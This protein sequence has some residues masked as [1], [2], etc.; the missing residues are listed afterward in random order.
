MKIV[1]RIEFETHE[2]EKQAEMLNKIIEI[3]A[4]TAYTEVEKETALNSIREQISLMNSS[5]A[6]MAFTLGYNAGRGNA[7]EKDLEMYS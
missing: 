4:S 2:L 3:S 1:H 6:S 5:M 7:N